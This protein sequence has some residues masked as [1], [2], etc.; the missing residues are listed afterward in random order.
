MLTGGLGIA[1]FASAALAARDRLELAGRVTITADANPDPNALSPITVSVRLA[2]GREL[3]RTLTAI[4]GNPA[5]PM[6]HEAHLAKFRTNAKAAA[7]P[8]SDG[9]IAA[10]IALVDDLEHQPSTAPLLAL[11]FGESA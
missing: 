7:K 6:T 1:D 5:N 9:A 11:A 8:L 4:Y 10:L 3:A 2:D